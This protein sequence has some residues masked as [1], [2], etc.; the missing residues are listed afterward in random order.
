MLQPIPY[1]GFDGTC[2]DAMRFYQRV[3]GGRLEAM[4]RTADTPMAQHAPPEAA[5]RIVHACLVLPGGASL[6]GADAPHGVAHEGIRGVSITLN[7][8]TPD[9]ARRIFEALGEGGTVTM[10]MAPTFWAQAFGML[11][12]R[13]GTPWIVNGDMQ[14]MP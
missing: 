2:A 4:L 3:L 8:D 6:Y 12:D 5:D 9:E 1:L 11:T 10:A 7:Y 13:F 14:P